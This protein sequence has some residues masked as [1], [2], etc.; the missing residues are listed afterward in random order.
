MRT[1]MNPYS[2][3]NSNPQQQPVAAAATATVPQSERPQLKQPIPNRVGFQRLNPTRL[4]PISNSNNRSNSSLSSRVDPAS[5][6]PYKVKTEQFKEF[7]RN[8]GPYRF[9]ITLTFNK[10]TYFLQK[11]EYVNRFIRYYNQIIFCHDY[12][13]K[14]RFMSGFAFFEHHASLE[15]VDSLHVHILIRTHQRFSKFDEV[16]HQGIFKKA[17]LKVQNHKH[18]NVFSSRCIDLQMVWDELGAIEYDT[19][20]IWDGNL[21]LIKII[22]KEGLSDK[23][24]PTS[25]R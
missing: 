22:G 3:I 6:N 1:I 23:I 20:N 19:K 9:F 2:R 14:D 8:T 21:D 11:C 7:I 10:K 12:E 24:A 15:M 18:Q 17:A 25:Y 4:N 5:D 16:A 13:R